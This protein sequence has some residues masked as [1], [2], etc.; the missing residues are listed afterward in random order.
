MSQILALDIAGHPSKWIDCEQAVRYYVRGMILWS[1]GDT[2]F[3]YRGGICRQTGCQ[4]IISASSIIAVNGPEMR[5]GAFVTPQ[6]ISDALFVR[7]RHMC[8]YCG[9]IFP[10]RLL[11]QDHVRPRAQG[12]EHTWMNLVASCHGC[13]HRKGNRTPE[14]A[15]M[16]LLYVPYVP[17]RYEHFI[18]INRRI[19]ADQMDYLM[20]RVP[21]SSRLHV[22]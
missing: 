19:L 20:S 1:L 14:Q 17:N 3:T 5:I 6:V 11:T 22:A 12:G 10:T 2:T 13:N 4:S 9:E 21:A 16:P 7:D 18:L 15:G 8:A